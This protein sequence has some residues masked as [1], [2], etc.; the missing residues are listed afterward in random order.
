MKSLQL[1]TVFAISIL[2][3]AACGG[4]KEDEIKV[5]EGMRMVDLSK[6][7]KTFI[8]FT[9]D[10]TVG[11]LEILE[12]PGGLLEIKVGKQFDIVI[13]EGEEDIAFKKADLGNDDLYKI[14]QFF[15]DE[16]N[17]I[18]WEWAIGDLPSEFH[19]ITVQ[20]IGNSAYTFEDAR[21]SENAPFS[22]S[23]IEKML[24][25]C[26]NIKPVPKKEE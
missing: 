10:S 4:K 24:E 2:F 16:P 14:K 6:N 11:K 22:K 5:P 12:Q 9:P 19:F 21:N 7:G 20:K 8:I 17:T 18:A 25:S 3:F 13:K 15:V 26:K 1:L 23:A